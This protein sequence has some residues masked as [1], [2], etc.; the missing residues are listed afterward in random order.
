MGNEKMDAIRCQK[1][2]SALYTYCTTVLRLALLEQLGG[3][4][5]VKWGHQL[6]DFKET[7]DGTVDLTQRRR[8]KSAKADLVVGAD[9]IL[10]FSAEATY[11]RRHNS[12]A[13]P[14]LYCNTRHLS[15]VG[16]RRCW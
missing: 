1:L 10:E 12:F 16:S 5:A 2:P 7:E 3:H 4:D 11:W 9:G 13:I 15:F 8:V 14:R 6:V